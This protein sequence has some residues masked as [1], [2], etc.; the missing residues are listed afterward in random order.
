MM[1]ALAG[2]TNTNEPFSGTLTFYDPENDA[3]IGL[4]FSNGLLLF[5]G[6]L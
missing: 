3:T 2:S 4:Q 6:E 1:R 5:T